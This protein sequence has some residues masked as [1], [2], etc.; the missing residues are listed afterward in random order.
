M[1][2]VIETLSDFGGTPRKLLYLTKYI[3]QN[4]CKLVFL[5]FRPYSLEEKFE[6]LEKEFTRYGATVLDMN[7][8][9][10]LKLAWK[11]RSEARRFGADVIC[12][13]Y[14]RPLITGY[15]ASKVLGLPFIHHEHSSAHYRKG[16]GRVLGK[17][18]LPKAAAVICNSR[19]TSDTIS[20]SYR[21]VSKKLHVIYNPVEERIVTRE[22]NEIRR[23]IGVREEDI[24]IGHVGGMIPERDQETLI[25]AFHKIH[26]EFKH[27]KLILIGDG[28][29]RP[30]LESLAESLEIKSNVIF[31]GYTRGVWE[32]LSALD[33]YV[34][35]T[36]DEGF[37]IAVVEAMLSRLPVI[38]SDRGA[39][40]E[41]IVENESGFLYP[42][43]DNESLA[44]RIKL[45]LESPR[46]R[47]EM[48]L[49]ACE[50]AKVRFSPSLFASN[51]FRLVQNILVD[52]NEF[53]RSS[54]QRGHSWN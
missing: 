11:V 21:A 6:S 23:E 36:L 20:S 32:Y 27:S 2:H 12:T 50:V 3:D 41:L 42:G 10:P 18:C 47:K 8:T 33:I 24:L 46:K 15:L 29:V 4:Q 26:S 37:G 35:P 48:G 52:S 31:T 40:P 7:T 38:L 16:M 30:R 53:Y 44:K 9:S 54:K 45:L 49:K 13:H 17:F 34:N 28:P 51:Y 19:Y 39:H 22:R 43:S 1:L 25:K 14:T 5:L